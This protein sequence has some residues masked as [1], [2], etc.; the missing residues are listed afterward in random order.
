M[1]P[2]TPAPRLGLLLVPLPPGQLW[3]MLWVSSMTELSP[4]CAP[5]APPA[6][7]PRGSAASTAVTQAL[8]LA[9][10]PLV[11]HCSLPNSPSRATSPTVSCPCSAPSAGC[12]HTRL[13][14][15]PLE[16]HSWGSTHSL[17]GVK[18]P[19]TSSSSSQERSKMNSYV[20]AV[21]TAWSNA[22]RPSCGTEPWVAAAGER[23]AG[24]PIRLALLAPQHGCHHLPFPPHATSCCSPCGVLCHS[25]VG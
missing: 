8:V 21:T 1:P 12:H 23:G 10:E 16:P 19:E 3:K 2:I 13:C 25:V 22:P 5:R 17:H 14:G 11:I 20:Q 24:L 6:P 7:A 4:V 9:Q 18:L 15:T